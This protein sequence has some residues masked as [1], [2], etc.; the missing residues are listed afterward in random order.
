MRTSPMKTKS[1]GMPSPETIGHPTTKITVEVGT[2]FLDLFSAQLYSSPQKAFEE[3]IS[4][5]WDA[6]AD[7][8]DVRISIDL[9]APNSTMCV[10][11]NGASMD[12]E[13]LHGLWRIAFSPKRGT[14]VQYGRRVIGK[15]GIGKLATYVLADKLTYICKASDGVI[16]R[17][18]MDYG[19]IARQHAASQER[20]ISDLELEVYEVQQTELDEALMNVYDGEVILDLIRKE[21]P[22]PES[23]LG[24]DEF[25]GTKDELERPPSGTWT[26]VVLSDLKSTGRELKIGVLQRMLEAALPFGSDM[27]ISINGELITSSKIDTPIIAEW[28]IGPELGIDTIEIDEDE[29]L[30][31]STS[32][33][34]Q[35]MPQIREISIAFGTSPTPFVELPE[36]GRLTGRVRLFAERISS[37]KSEERGA[38]NGFHVNVLGRVI[39]QNDPSFGEKNL[40][41]HGKPAHRYL[42]ARGWCAAFDP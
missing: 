16:R 40:N 15:F 2:A 17:V 23:A 33:S 36:V 8:V 25:G 42:C 38:S 31:G 4:N 3:L 24:E 29:S 18:T 39:N 27:A 20:M 9:Q 7:C 37:G 6:G 26:L 32:S 10:L 21:V 30:S 19:N 1:K 28:T 13:G 34:D 12:E 5:S 11:D 41:C 14:P 35:A 22:R